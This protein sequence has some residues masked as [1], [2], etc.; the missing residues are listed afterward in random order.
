MRQDLYDVQEALNRGCI[1]SQALIGPS[2]CNKTVLSKLLFCVTVI[3]ILHEVEPLYIA[4]SIDATLFR[5]ASTLCIH[6]QK[7]FELLTDSLKRIS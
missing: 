5:F 6:P 2:I 3:F 4:R 1:N 7:P